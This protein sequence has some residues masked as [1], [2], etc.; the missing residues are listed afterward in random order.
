MVRSCD[1]HSEFSGP[2]PFSICLGVNWFVEHTPATSLSY[3]PLI[4][5][6]IFSDINYTKKKIVQ[7]S[8]KESLK[9][10]WVASE[11]RI[12]VIISQFPY[13]SRT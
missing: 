4:P 7:I 2:S 5:W 1:L 6:C 12:V 10:V 13:F 8:K 11:N 9:F 3:L